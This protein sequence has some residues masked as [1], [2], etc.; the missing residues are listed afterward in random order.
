MKQSLEGLVEGVFIVPPEGKM[1]GSEAVELAE[2]TPE[3]FAGDR[4]AGMSMLSNSRTPFYTRGT[5]IWNSRQVSIVSLEE[6]AEV[7]PRMG[8]P[9]IQPAWLGANLAISGIPN[10]SRLPAGARL[11]FP[12]RAVLIVQAEN[13]PC[14]TAGAEIQTHYPDIPDLAAQFPKQGLHKRGIVA[15]VERP[16]AIRPGDAVKVLIPEQV[17]YE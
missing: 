9:E 13:G 15:V 1:I 16:G 6:L 8:I 12:D 2:I 7:A 17:L 5:P 3:G 4:H 14:L 10:L 11:F